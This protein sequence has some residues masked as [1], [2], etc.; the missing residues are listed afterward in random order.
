MD[1]GTVRNRDKLDWKR[2]PYWQKLA[3]GQSLGFRPSKV[4][5]GGT[6]IARYYDPDTRK[7]QTRALGDFG[8][9]PPNEQFT[10]AS[11][12]AR[13]WFAHLSGGGEADSLTVGQAC[14]R[15]AL[16][17]SEPQKRFVRHIYSDPIANIKLEKLAAR[18]V[19]EWRKRLEAKPAVLAKPK[20]GNVPTRKRSTASVNRDMVPLR[21]ALNRARDDGYNLTDAA[22][23]V[24]I[25]PAKATARRSLYLD[26]DQRVALLEA[27]PAD[28][29]ALCRGLCSLPLRPGA[30]AALRVRDFN[31]RNGELIL[32]YDKGVAGRRL[33]LPEDTSAFFK[34][35]GHGKLPAAYLFTRAD[36]KPWNKDG[37]KTP[38]KKAAKAANLPTDTVAYTLRHSTI[39]DLVTGGLDLLTVGKLAGTSVVMIERHYGHLRHEHA[40]EALRKL[41]L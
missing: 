16:G 1:L 27:L 32:S 36:G 40:K 7:K 18:H 33:M 21:A 28:A 22:W 31:P 4:G 20:K 35:Q 39:T 6:W 8:H 2:E 17:R 13:E 11:K 24:A 15:Y 14:E 37:W 26:R 34:A 3:Q 10:A 19:S 30:L 5:K 41:A 29:A 25:K 38:I 9:L 23:R 12:G